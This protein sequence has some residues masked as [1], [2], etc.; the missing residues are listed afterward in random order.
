MENNSNPSNK[1]IKYTL[2]AFVS[3]ELVTS[4]SGI[5]ELL[6]E[7]HLNIVDKPELAIIDILNVQDSVRVKVKNIKFTSNTIY[8]DKKSFLKKLRPI[9]EYIKSTAIASTDTRTKTKNNITRIQKSKSKWSQQSDLLQILNKNLE[10]STD[11]ISFTKLLFKFNALKAFQTVHLFIHE[12]GQSSSKHLEIMADTHRIYANS[13]NEF[14]TLFQ[15]IKKS[16]NRS[17]GQTSIKG[18]SFEI[19]GTF[20]AHEFSLDKHNLILI[21]SRNDFLTQTKDEIDSFNLLTKYLPS[22]FEL[23]LKAEYFKNNKDMTQK[24]L[25]EVP[26]LVKLETENK[27]VYTNNHTLNSN[28]YDQYRLDSG[29]ILQIGNI[30]DSIIKSPEAFHQER[31]SLL[32]ELLNTLKHELSNPLFGLQLTTELLLLDDLVDDQEEFLKEILNSIKRSQ[33]IIDNFSKLYTDTDSSKS[34]NLKN[35]INE[36]FTLSKSESR[37]LRKSI[38]FSGELEA[39]SDDFCIDVNPTM[40]AQILFNLVVNSSQAMKNT[41]KPIF[42]IDIRKVDNNLEFKI[43]DNGPGIPSNSELSIFKPFYTTKEQGT[44]L[45]LSIS[46]SLAKKL[47]GELIYL[48]NESGTTFLLRLPYENTC[49]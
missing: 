23:M 33:S 11:L 35:L 41:D 12:K 26:L 40:L 36:V 7:F 31:V 39:N 42:K 49:S 22:Y 34:V 15:S 47:N 5:T 28:S 2:N 43:Y 1:E 13:A 48:I 19:L 30:S 21:I 3:Q 10:T 4:E 38:T 14:S 9:L 16:K 27:N 6:D 25:S 37:M 44:G 45:G 20:L 8:L 18:F 24:S 29:K 32:G 46:T 17:F